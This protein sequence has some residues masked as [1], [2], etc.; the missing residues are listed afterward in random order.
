MQN[1]ANYSIS[2]MIYTIWLDKHT[3]HTTIYKLRG[4]IYIRFMIT[5][6]H[7]KVIMNLIIYIYIYSTSRCVKENIFPEGKTSISVVL[8]NYN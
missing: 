7:S 2:L 3:L 8:V 1:T 5:F 6:P 4:A